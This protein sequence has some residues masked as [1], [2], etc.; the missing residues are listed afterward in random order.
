[1]K[2]LRVTSKHDE[3]A[4]IA[5]AVDVLRRGGTVAYPT[6]TLY[7][8][9]ADP[10][11]DAAIERL[12]AV[13]QRDRTQAIPVIAAD[14]DQALGVANF[15]SGDRR[16]ASAFWPGPLSLVVEAQPCVS[17][18]AIAVDGTVAIRVPN[19]PLA[20]RLAAEFGTC[21][22]ATSANLSGQ[23]ACAF[24]DDVAAVL[25]DRIDLLLDGGTAPG[26]PPSTI[27]AVRNGEVMLVR[28][29]AIAWERVLE[30]LQEQH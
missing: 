21:L 3:P 2:R 25:G 22:T 16:L 7:G 9:A 17:R 13:K 12:F 20:R 27:V 8:L 28:A 10:R 19:H 18:A 29:G 30:S 14:L 4:A 6:D 24:P 5:E 23:P 15:T 26:G 11:S 1:V